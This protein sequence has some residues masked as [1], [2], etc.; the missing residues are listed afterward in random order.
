M[1]DAWSRGDRY[2]PFIGRWS[3]L[4]APRFLDWVGA[5]AGRRW[6]DIGAGTGALSA[7][8]LDRCA[9]TGVVGYEQSPEFVAWARAQ[10]VDERVTF[11]VADALAIPPASA[12]V[13][14]SGLVVNFLPDQPAAIGAMAAAAPG[15][16]VAAYVWDYAEGMQL[17]RA[18]WD[19]AVALDAAAS[20][21]DEAHRFPICGPEPLADLW[22][23][24]GLGEVVTSPLDIP[25]EFTDFDDLW[26]PFL[27]GQGPA[28]GYVASLPEPERIR[29]RERLRASLPTRPDGAIAL[30]ARAW[31]VRGVAPGP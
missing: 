4:V 25:T 9:P 8:V 7:A 1:T 12:D 16:V 26:T 31:A 5:P 28:P 30:R 18:F 11:V 13:V 17:L 19:A 21:L 20:T 14:V 10:V 24:A 15:G 6:A 27:G 2:E 22:V 3:R 23:G 29:L